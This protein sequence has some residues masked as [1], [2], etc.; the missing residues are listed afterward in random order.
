MKHVLIAAAIAGSA[1]CAMAQDF[2]LTL[3]PSVTQVFSE[4]SFTI[5]V[6]GDADVGTHMLG[7]AF[8]LESD[9]DCIASMSWTPASWSGF[10]TDGG[11]AG[12]GDYNQV[13]FGQL[14][15][16]GIFPPAP[17][18]ELG[19][20]IG[21]FLVTAEAFSGDMPVEFQ[22]VAGSPFTLE[23][24]DAVTGETFQSSNGNLTLGSTTVLF[25][26]IPSPGVLSTACIGGL[27]A[28]RRRRVK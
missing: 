3:V 1:S 11:Y 12:D 2:S 22:L 18:S 25:G 8:A 26:N 19:S 13:I 28:S 4:G 27:L 10:N 24:V 20:A 7:G 16:G 6:Y 21:S 5:T 23:T 14:V 9:G 15:L 17:G